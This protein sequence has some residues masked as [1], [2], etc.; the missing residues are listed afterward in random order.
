L[1]AT[2]SSHD[3]YPIYTEMVRLA[4]DGAMFKIAQFEKQFRYPSGPQ[5]NPRIACKSA[6]IDSPNS[7]AQLTGR[8]EQLIFQADSLLV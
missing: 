4:E 6:G 8:S 1:A 2:T 5:R 3:P 7:E